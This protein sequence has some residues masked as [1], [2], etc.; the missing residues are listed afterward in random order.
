MRAGRLCLVGFEIPY[1]LFCCVVHDENFTSI[2]V[3]S[4]RF[5]GTTG[6]VGVWT[7]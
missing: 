1:E 6:G 2:Q 7:W 5:T 3:D 4:I